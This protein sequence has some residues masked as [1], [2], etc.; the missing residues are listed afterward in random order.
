M[1]K[2]SFQ[3]IIHFANSYSVEDGKLVSDRIS[4][5]KGSSNINL[6]TEKPS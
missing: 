4:S 2:V 5:D 3:G 1:V 6:K